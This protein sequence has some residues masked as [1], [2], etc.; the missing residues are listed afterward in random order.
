MAVAESNFVSV[1]LVEYTAL[2]IVVIIVVGVVYKFVKWWRVNPRTLYTAARRELGF[3]GIIRIFF[4]ELVNRVGLN[5]DMITESKTRR[6]AHLAVF[7]GFILLIFA[8]TWVYIFYRSG[9]PRPLSDLG[10][11]AGNVGGVLVIGGSSFMLFRHAIDER[12]KRGSIGDL[13]FL[14]MLLLATAT[15]FITEFARLSAF[16]YLTYAIYAIHLVLVG[17]LFISAPFTQFFHALLTPFLRFTGRLEDELH[18]K[19]V[20]EYPFYKRTEMSEEAAHIKST[21]NEGTY[22]SWLRPNNK[23][24]LDDK[25]DEENL[26]GKS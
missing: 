7:W 6:A 8:T 15:G 10:K 16:E 11:I 19:G 20:I 22:P 9:S 25:K 1:G 18:K 5:R 14:L 12:S 3:S 21:D 26:Q 24:N 17:A 2:V 13:T 23:E 4:D